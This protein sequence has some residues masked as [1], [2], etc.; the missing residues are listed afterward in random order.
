MKRAPQSLCPR[1]LP[2]D[3]FHPPYHCVF[4]TFFNPLPAS[5]PS[6]PI[7]GEKPPPP[8]PEKC[9]FLR[10]CCHCSKSFFLTPF[11]S[12]AFFFLFPRRSSPGRKARGGGR[13]GCSQW[14]EKLGP[15][16]LGLALFHP[17]VLGLRVALR[18]FFLPSLSISVS[19]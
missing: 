16:L 14:V 4:H 1:H 10:K 12:Q 18:S 8:P 9:H 15:V 19:I 6:H 11:H 2:S 5:P 17:H 7:K 13:Q 3:L